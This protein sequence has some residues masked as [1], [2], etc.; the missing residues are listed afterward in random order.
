MKFVALHALLILGVK[1]LH[2]SLSGCSCDQ[3]ASDVLVN[4]NSKT[5]SA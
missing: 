1:V 4:V 5:G 2:I 3:A